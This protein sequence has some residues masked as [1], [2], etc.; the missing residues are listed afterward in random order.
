MIHIINTTYDANCYWY[1]YKKAINEGDIVIVNLPSGIV[2]KCI[3]VPLSSHC[4][5][6]CDGCDL[7]N[8]DT[9]QHCYI[10]R[11]TSNGFRP[12]CTYDTN[13]TIKFKFKCLDKVLEDL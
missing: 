9:G 5:Y 1:M 7:A 4:N 11:R 6:A 13:R 3:A 12:L 8:K 2:K 10:I